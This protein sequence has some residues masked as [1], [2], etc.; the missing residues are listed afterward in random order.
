VF[1]SPA[2]QHGDPKMMTGEGLGA[3]L[4]Q[5]LLTAGHILSH[6]ATG[7]CKA[8]EFVTRRATVLPIYATLETYFPAESQSIYDIGR[9]LRGGECLRRVCLDNRIVAV[10]AAD[11]RAEY[12]DLL[13]HLHLRLVEAG[14]GLGR[15]IPVASPIGQLAVYVTLS[16]VTGVFNPV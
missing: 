3:S 11:P 9:P 12:R 13:S 8:R 4:I 7:Q 14:S 16:I 15:Q 2:G 5:R 6:I 1:A 10:P